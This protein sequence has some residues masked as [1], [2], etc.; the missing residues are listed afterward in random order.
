MRATCR[1]VGTTSQT[2][3]GYEDPKLLPVHT[4]SHGHGADR[5][6]TKYQGTTETSL[7]C[8]GQPLQP[9][10]AILHKR[11]IHDRYSSTAACHPQAEL[12]GKSLSSGPC[13]ECV[14]SGERVESRTEG[15]TKP[16]CTS[17]MHA[18]LRF[19]DLST[20]AAEDADTRVVLS[21]AG[22]LLV[23]P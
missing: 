4:P 6:S 2:N 17:H 14:R 23:A 15:G 7:M 9:C 10:L 11:S 3:G 18:L 20:P 12:C 1:S 8:S 16:A 22:G 5:A 13:V 19:S 21:H